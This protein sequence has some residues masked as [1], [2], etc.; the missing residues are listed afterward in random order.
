MLYSHQSISIK[1][2]N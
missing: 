2:N 1:A